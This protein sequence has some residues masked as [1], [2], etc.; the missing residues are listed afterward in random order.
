MPEV[1]QPTKTLAKGEKIKPLEPG[2]RFRECP[3]LW[4]LAGMLFQ[5]IFQPSGKISWIFYR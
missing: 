3:G 2:Y 1:F 5:G 4:A